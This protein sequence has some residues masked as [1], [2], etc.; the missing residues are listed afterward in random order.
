MCSYKRGGGENK[1][2]RSRNSSIIKSK[3]NAEQT[4]SPFI[5]IWLKRCCRK[6]GNGKSRMLFVEAIEHR[7]E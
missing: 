6:D 3:S 2:V 1:A 7:G 4:S 5:C